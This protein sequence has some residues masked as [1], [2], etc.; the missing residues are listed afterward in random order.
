[1]LARRRD[2][3]RE[4]GGLMATV[5]TVRGPIDVAE[6]GRTLMHE[7]VFVMD[8]EAFQNF[9]RHWG[10]PYWDEDVR[11]ADAVAKLRAL[12]DAGIDTI[13]DPTAVGLGR[14]LPRIQ[15]VNA[16]VDINIVP[17]TGLYA[18]LE[19]PNFFKYRTPEAI[20]EFFIRELREGIDGTRVKPAFLKCAVEE[21]GLGGDVP[22]IVQAVAAAS[23]ETGAP[24][25]VH[26]NASARSGLVALDAFVEQ[27]VDP[28][29][30]VIAHAGDSNDLDYLR[31]IADR[32]A[33]LGCDRFGIEFF[34][35]MEDRIR[36]LAALTAE[37]YA[38]RIVLSHD[39][40]AFMDFFTGDPNLN[41]DELDYLLISREVLPALVDAGVTPDQIETMLVDVPR[42]F[43]GG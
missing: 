15:R 40:A 41:E 19:V 26:T 10:E 9:G 23:L 27:G 21:Y 8:P 6:L 37:G 35:P 36:T 28:E 13:V 34:N 42:R 43:F 29:K 30:I 20:A 38:D 17:A 25:V 22:R 3:T 24:I 2:E 1:M 12:K 31:A 16:E 32:G 39:A 5:E 4:R 11:V 18:F 33:I 7:H 14:Y